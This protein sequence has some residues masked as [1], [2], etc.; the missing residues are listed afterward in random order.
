MGFLDALGIGN[1]PDQLSLPEILSAIPAIAGPVLMA[2]GKRVGLP[3][4]IGLSAIGG[5]GQTLADRRRTQQQHQGLADAIAK[6]PG[7][8]DEMRQSLSQAVKLGMDPSSIYGDVLKSEFKQPASMK[9]FPISDG[10]Q[11]RMFD[12][13]TESQIPPGWFSA[14]FKPGTTKTPLKTIYGPGGATQEVGISAGYKP[15]EGWSL[16]APDKPITINNNIPLSP[17]DFVQDPAT[18]KWGYYNRTG[19]FE[20]VSDAPPNRLPEQPK[21]GPKLPH[22]PK[23]I[24][25]NYIAAPSSAIPG[26]VDLTPSPKAAKGGMFSRP[27]TPLR[28][29]NGKLIKPGD[30]MQIGGKTVI[31][32]GNFD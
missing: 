8:T 6:M 15:P 24:T 7:V 22:L 1:Q 20:P 23:E 31:W 21:G 27:L 5:L 29:Y 9:P 12:P 4:G 32:D 26:V 30:T 13:A 10:K 14:S 28:Y 11:E 16:K 19:T 17:S 25:D 3:L 2:R 18:H